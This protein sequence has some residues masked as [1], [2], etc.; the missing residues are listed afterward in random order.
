MRKIFSNIILVFTFPIKLLR[1]TKI[2]NFVGGLIFGALFSLMVN[3]TTVKVQEDLSKQR[4]L[5]ALE[6]EIV[7][8]YLTANQFVRAEIDAYKKTDEEYL[9][10]DNVLSSRYET[11]MWESGNVAAYLF[12]I[13]PAVAGKIQ[14]YYGIIIKTANRFI[15]E[16]EENFR[17]SYHVCTPSYEFLENGKRESKKVC[18]KLLRIALTTQTIYTDNVY[19]SVEEIRKDFHPTQDRL[20]NPWLRFLLGNKAYEVMKTNTNKP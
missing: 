9:V 11:R 5:E 18:N 16:N 1:K 7:E 2:D 13:D 4:T 10:L 12:E 6:R 14:A 3:I 8:H 17:R 20:N 15:N 19:S